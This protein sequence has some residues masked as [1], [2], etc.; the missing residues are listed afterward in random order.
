M[1][2]ALLA[3]FSASVVEVEVFCAEEAVRRFVPAVACPGCPPFATPTA[4]A[5]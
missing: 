2:G 4:Q 3:P 1:H 5:H